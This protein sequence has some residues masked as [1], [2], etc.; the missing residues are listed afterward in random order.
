MLC[1]LNETEVGRQDLSC[2]VFG[3]LA[4]IT[5]SDPLDWFVGFYQ[6]C[7]PSHLPLVGGLA[8]FVF[9]LAFVFVCGVC[10]CLFSCFASVRG[11]FTIPPRV[12]D[13]DD[14]QCFTARSAMR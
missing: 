9:G 4:G 8:V 13:L 7:D 10:V 3:F 2:V 5:P 11:F 6:G 1:R 12:V 14:R